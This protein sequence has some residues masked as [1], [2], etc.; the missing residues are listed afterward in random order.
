MDQDLN[1]RLTNIIEQRR[2]KG[3]LERDLGAVGRELRDQAV[4]LKS[5]SLKL[6]K[7]KVDVEKLERT[8][9]TALFYSV[10]GS[11]EQQLEKERRELL[12]A[13]LSF[14]QTKHQVDFLERERDRIS[15]QLGKLKDIDLAYEA[16]ISEKE[17][18]L[19]RANQP[20][21]DELMTLSEQVANLNSELEEIS[22]A[23]AAGN[24]AISSL[25]Q[26]IS[27]LESAK[28]WGTWDML[29]GGL[30]S[31]A[32]KHSRIDAA[33]SSIHEVESK[34]SQFRRELSD[35]QNGID[36]Q[37]NI[38]A[39]ESFADYI[40]DGL[41][42]DWIVQSK[43]V[44]SLERCKQGMVRIDRAVTELENLE[45]GVQDQVRNLKEKRTRLIERT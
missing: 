30:I 27:A 28:G 12:A 34:M 13:Q 21:A 7:E 19:R 22:E 8:N 5:L 26:V 1:D 39:F 24:E 41:I 2:L 15:D 14:Q 40:F 11:R 35:I 31:T 38:D 29:G 45:Q 17:Q 43:I 44:D 9:L 20:V 23:I 25:E 16:L 18:F 33:R 36:L 4:R 6:E 42:F 3:K 10:L 32:I 37:I